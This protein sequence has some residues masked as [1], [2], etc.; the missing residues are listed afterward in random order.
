MSTTEEKINSLTSRDSDN[1]GAFLN[2]Y[3]EDLTYLMEESKIRSLLNEW[4]F[5]R[6]RMDMEAF[7]KC[8]S[9]DGSMHVGFF[10]GHKDEFKKVVLAKNLD[11]RHFPSEPQIKISGDRAVVK[12]YC[13][14]LVRSEKPVTVDVFAHMQFYDMLIKEAGEWKIFKRYVTF[15]KDRLDY[16]APTPIT[17]IVYGILTLLFLRKYPKNTRHLHFAWKQKFKLKIPK[18]HPIMYKSKEEEAVIYEID[19]WIQHKE[20]RSKY[21]TRTLSD[22]MGELGFCH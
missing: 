20:T 16:L 7:D 22:L 21:A 18:Y 15:D 3:N 17:S 4:V 2:T 5:C 11:S 10:E 9:N 12:T 14:L 13:F 19:S 1:K 6:D 8:W